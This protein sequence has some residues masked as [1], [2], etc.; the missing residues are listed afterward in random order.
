MAGTRLRQLAR[1]LVVAYA[2]EAELVEQVPPLLGHVPDPGAVG[3]L[4]ARL[5]LGVE[6]RL[7]LRE[8]G[9]EELARVGERH[10]PRAELDVGADHRVT[11][12]LR[13]DRVAIRIADRDHVALAHHLRVHLLGGDLGDSGSGGIAGREELPRVLQHLGAAD[14]LELAA[15]LLLPTSHH[16]TRGIEHARLFPAAHQQT[17]ARGV[18]ERRAERDEQDGRGGDGEQA[19]DD[20]AAAKHHGH[21]LARRRLPWSRAGRETEREIGGHGIVPSVTDSDTGCCRSSRR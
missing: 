12:A 14:D 6:L 20:Q 17:P 5:D 9:I 4:A 21:E 13:H 18:F 3:V 11:H 16:L 15:Q 2:Q 7:R 10:V 8:L 1:G 19:Q